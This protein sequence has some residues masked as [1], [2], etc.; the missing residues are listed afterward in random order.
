MK[1]SVTGLRITKVNKKKKHCFQE[2]Q[3]LARETDAYSTKCNANQ[4]KNQD[5][6]RNY[7]GDKKSKKWIFFWEYRRQ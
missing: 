3:S 1:G 5:N 7:Y 6:K 2:A 4:N